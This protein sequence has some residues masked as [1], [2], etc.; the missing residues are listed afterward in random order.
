MSW[1]WYRSFLG[2]R[3]IKHFYEQISRSLMWPQHKMFSALALKAD[4]LLG[5]RS[6]ALP[7]HCLWR[8]HSWAP[9]PRQR[10]PRLCF[11]CW[12]ADLSWLLSSQRRVPREYFTLHV[13][14]KV[15]ALQSSGEK[16]LCVSKN[17]DARK[18]SAI[19]KIAQWFSLSTVLWNSLDHSLTRTLMGCLAQFQFL[20]SEKPR[21]AQPW[22]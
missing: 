7:S 1:N 13:V 21:Q 14:L 12:G 19:I 22:A 18:I 9:D 17:L 20:S 10:V 16:M 15:Q 8:E 11:C 3:L 6:T 5:A 4:S 2:V